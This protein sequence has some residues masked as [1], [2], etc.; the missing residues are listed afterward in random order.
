M[1]TEAFERDFGGAPTPWAEYPDNV[2][3]WAAEFLALPTDS[4]PAQWIARSPDGRRWFG[5]K[6]G[7]YLADQAMKRSG[8]SLAQLATAPTADILRWAEP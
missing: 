3:E 1:S 2:A 7:T 8:Q 6:V 5:Y 4:D